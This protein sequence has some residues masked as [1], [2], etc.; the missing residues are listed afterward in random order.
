MPKPENP[1]FKMH[2]EE[3]EHD[4]EPGSAMDGQNAGPQSRADET[5]APTAYDIKE[6]HMAFPDLSS[7]ELREITIL[8]PGTRLEQGAKYIDL[9]ADPVEEIAARADMV[10]TSDNWFV[11]KNSI[12]YQLYNRLLGI[13]N[14]ERTGEA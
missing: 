11:P 9:K 6:F 10:S 3:F 4:L 5:N 12:D 8:L 7:D 2:P 14:P 13:Q 1:N